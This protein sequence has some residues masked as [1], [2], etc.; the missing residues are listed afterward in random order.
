MKRDFELH[1]KELHIVKRG[2]KSLSEDLIAALE[3]GEPGISTL[4]FWVRTQKGKAAPI[5]RGCTY[6][7]KV[8]IWDKEIKRI[9]DIPKKG[10][11]D[12]GQRYL[13]WFGI[14]LDEM[15]RMRKSKDDW[16]EFFYP[17]VEMG[18]DRQDCINYLKG[19]TYSDGTP[20]TIVKSACSFCPFHSPNTW[21]E[22]RQ[23]E[24]DWEVALK[25]DQAIEDAYHRM[26]NSWDEIKEEVR[27]HVINGELDIAVNEV[28]RRN[29]P[30]SEKGFE[31]FTRALERKGEAT[32]EFFAYPERRWT[33]IFGL[34]QRPYLTQDLMPLK[35]IDFSEDN[36]D[37]FG[38]EC[39]GVCGM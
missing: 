9:F 6:D 23:N 32:E 17:L 14:S 8:N 34:D 26:R 15:R 11:L 21:R 22:I 3:S 7:Y 31:K 12:D 39:A 38:D 2:R 1:D 10:T 16:R 5:R 28:M 27:L 19:K 24:S 35:E 4:P 20:V 33:R 18:W 13:H 25:L 37:F 36:E 30:G 29:W